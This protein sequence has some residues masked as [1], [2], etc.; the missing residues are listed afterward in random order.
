MAPVAALLMLTEEEDKVMTILRKVNSDSAY[1][2]GHWTEAAVEY[3]VSASAPREAW[4]RLYSAR[5]SEADENAPRGAL[6][7][8]HPGGH[9]AAPTAPAERPQPGPEYE[10]AV[11]GGGA[12]VLGDG[13]RNNSFPLVCGEDTRFKVDGDLQY[14]CPPPS[15]MSVVSSLQAVS[16]ERR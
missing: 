14:G 15:G 12:T 1:I 8:V 9:P 16:V 13:Y 3:A 6:R 5:R 10:Q 7:R 4:G 2:P 11:R